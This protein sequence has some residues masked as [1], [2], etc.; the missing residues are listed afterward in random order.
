MTRGDRISLMIGALALGIPLFAIVVFG[1]SKPHSLHDGSTDAWLAWLVIAAVA[2][3]AR[4]LYV[5][6]VEGRR[7]HN[8]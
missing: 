2:G 3:F 7:A 5:S 8:D 4:M 6:D 1:D